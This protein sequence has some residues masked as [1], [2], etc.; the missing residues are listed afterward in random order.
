[1]LNGGL[2]TRDFL[3]EGIRSTSDFVALNDA[4]VAAI[5]ARVDTLFAGFGQLKNP[6]EAE[7]E[8]ELIWP[9]LETLSWADMSVQQNLWPRRA[10]MCPTRCCSEVRRRRQRPPRFCLGKGLRTGCAS[11]RRSAGTGSSIARKPAAGASR[12]CLPR[13]CC[14]IWAVSMT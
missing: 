9:L 11:S 2:F 13:K 8:K 10:T 4:V 7:T 5:R 12:A 14:V 6:T 1:L 3:V